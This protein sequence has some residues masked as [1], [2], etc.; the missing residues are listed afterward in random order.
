MRPFVV[1]VKF[2]TK[3]INKALAKRYGIDLEQ[4]LAA[5]ENGAHLSLYP[6]SE[7]ISELTKLL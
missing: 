3:V 4:F 6:G 7:D 5:Q 1:D 2:I